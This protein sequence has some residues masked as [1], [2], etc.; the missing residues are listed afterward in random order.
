[1]SGAG[2]A[3]PHPG[4]R[5]VQLGD[6]GGY[7]HQPGGLESVRGCAVCC[8][9]GLPPTPAK[10]TTPP[11]PN[12]SAALPRLSGVLSGRVRVPHC[13]W[14]AGGADHRQPR[15][16]RA[17]GSDQGC[18]CICVASGGCTT[19]AQPACACVP[20]VLRAPPAQTWRGRSLKRTPP[21]WP[22]GSSR[23]ASTTTGRCP[24]ALCSRLG[25]RR[26][27]SGATRTGVSGFEAVP[28]E[29]SLRTTQSTLPH[30][31]AAHQRT[32]HTHTTHTHHTLKLQ[33][34]RGVCG[35]RADGVV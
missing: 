19:T 5:V 2:A 31:K 17:C 33:C 28:A 24:W 13:V 15:C 27:A 10:H 25:C 35:R 16:V 30:S 14:R 9:Q 11:P 20:R 1:M 4:A 3:A 23:S 26:C 22:P 32:P 8:R 18:A 7:K 6:L 12:H 29:R 34:A 21:T